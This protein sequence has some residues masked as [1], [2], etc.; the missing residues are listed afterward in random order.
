MATPSQIVGD[1]KDLDE[2]RASVSQSGASVEYVPAEGA[3]TIDA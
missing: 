3:A 2:K 1:H